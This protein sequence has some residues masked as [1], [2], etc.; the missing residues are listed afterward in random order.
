[1]L[2]LK[3]FNISQSKKPTSNCII[4]SKNN[5]SKSSKKCKSIHIDFTNLFLTITTLLL[6]TIIIML[7][8][9]P[10]KYMQS[11]TAGLKLFFYAVVPSLLPFL[12]LSKLLT[13]LKVV[14]KISKFFASTTKKLFNL[15]PI[16]AYVF[17]MS[18]LCGYPIGAKLIGDLY[19]NKQISTIQAKSMFALCSTSGPIFVIG[20]VGVSLLNDYKLGLYIF[21]SHIISALICGLI[22]KSKENLPSNQES[23]QKQIRLSS[24][25][26][27]KSVQSTISGILTVAVYVSIFYM[28]IDIA[29]DIKLLG[30]SQSLFEKCLQV[31]NIDP[32][33][34][35]GL[36]SGII[37]MTR[38]CSE[39]ALGSSKQLQL[40]FCASLISFSGISII[41]QSLTF[42]SKTKMNAF[43]VL[44]TKCVHSIITII[45]ATGFSFL[46]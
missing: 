28:F 43:F 34:A 13:E 45:I 27:S 46:I 33:F 42:L 17:L 10:A 4:S 19:E 25:I 39:I 8:L 14:D 18:V 11:V 29:Y 41:L 3:N 21:A 31:F 35:K 2:H 32:I 9:H 5:I 6:V 23:T 7:L 20:T 24:D 26:L 38:G 16:S 40:I 37:E 15:P 1:M 30:V 22:F 36:S 12:F 44:G